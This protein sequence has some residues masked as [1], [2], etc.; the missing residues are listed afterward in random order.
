VG[1]SEY[2]ASPVTGLHCQYLE[3]AATGNT[4]TAYHVTIR[5]LAT[6]HGSKDRLSL[7]P[8]ANFEWDKLQSIE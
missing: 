2:V 4:Q 8:A 1:H 3:A 6:W 7:F 5:K